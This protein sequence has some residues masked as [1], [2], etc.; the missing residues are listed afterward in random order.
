MATRQGLNPLEKALPCHELTF[1]RKFIAVA[2][3]AEEILK[4]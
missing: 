3:E 1:L 2:D 4:M